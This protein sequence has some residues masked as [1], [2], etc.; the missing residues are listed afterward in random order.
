MQVW[1][2]INRFASSIGLVN[3][4]F[5]EQEGS[6][7]NYIYLSIEIFIAHFSQMVDSSDDS[8]SCGNSTVNG[9][10]RRVRGIGSLLLDVKIFDDGS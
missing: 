7:L 1:H 2:A 3:F 8:Y 6:V 4:A 5:G 10:Y 9:N